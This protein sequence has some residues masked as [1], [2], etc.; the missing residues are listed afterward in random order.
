MFR[1]LLKIFTSLGARERLI[2]AGAALIFVTAGVFLGIRWFLSNTSVVPGFG[3]AYKE[4]MVGQP[5]FINPVLAQSIVDQDMVTLAYSNLYDIADQVTL[6][7]NNLVWT[8]RLR[9]GIY[10]H[11]GEPLTADDVVFTIEKIQDPESRSPLTAT[12]EGVVAERVSE[13]EVKL[14]TGAPYVFFEDNIRKLYIAPKHLYEGVPLSN[15]RLSS[16]NLR[17]VGSGPYVFQGL[18]QEKNGFISGYTLK[19]NQNYFGASPRIDT[20]ELLFF[21]N[22]ED[23]LRAF[24]TARVDGITDVDPAWLPRVK[25]FHAVHELHMPSYYAIFLNQGTNDLL[26]SK[27]VR[28]ALNAAIPR[29]ALVQ[30]IFDGHASLASG[31]LPYAGIRTADQTL[32]TRDDIEEAR[33]ILEEAEVATDEEGRYGKITLVVPDLAFLVATGKA[34]EERWEELG[35]DVEVIVLEPGVV[36][37]EIIRT[38]NYDALLFGN[39]LSRNPDI[40]SFWH[41]NFRRRRAP[42]R[43]GLVTVAYHSGHAGAFPI[44]TKLYYS[45]GC[46]SAR[47]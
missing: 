6:A 17:P 45:N 29:Q 5:S 1:N 4:G 7:D 16:F 14:T 37:S 10:W 20:I 27:N 33:R 9:D 2:L 8:I 22:E 44:F 12:W 34:V 28:L 26:K 32:V 40:L 3:G 47:L 46:E 25:R 13:L 31:P 42:E 39:A 11:D 43:P 36:T 18:E 30:N 35:F 21:A 15:W 24:N 23:V 19:R 38:R 41:T